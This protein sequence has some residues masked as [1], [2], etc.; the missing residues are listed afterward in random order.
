MVGTPARVL[1]GACGGPCGGPAGCVRGC[2]VGCLRGCPAGCPV[3]RLPGGRSRRSISSAAPVRGSA[4]DGQAWC[5]VRAR[6]CACWCSLSIM[7][8]V[9]AGR[10]ARR[11]IGAEAVSGDHRIS[12]NSTRRGCRRRCA[13]GCVRSHAP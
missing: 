3:G 1:P 2:P 10:P 8:S 4:R 11:E 7:G 9:P 6:S 12:A 13:A 5:S